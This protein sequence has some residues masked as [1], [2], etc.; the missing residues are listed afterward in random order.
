MACSICPVGTGRLGGFFKAGALVEEH[1]DGVLQ[2]ISV[3]VIVDLEFDGTKSLVN[4]YYC[5]SSWN[6]N[7][8][9]IKPPEFVARDLVCGA[10]IPSNR[11]A[12]F[13]D[14]AGRLINDGIG[15]S[16]REKD[17]IVVAHL[18]IANDCNF[19]SFC[20]MPEL[21][22]IAQGYWAVWTKC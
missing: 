6:F 5:V 22:H 9:E 15:S 10:A 4:I 18:R 21:V 16:W 8:G 14:L 17:D 3:N 20:R 13:N 19:G 12:L 7:I 1:S 11:Q 2:D